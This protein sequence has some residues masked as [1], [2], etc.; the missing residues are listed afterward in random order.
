RRLDAP[1]IA[2]GALDLE[3]GTKTAVR[4]AYAGEREIPLEDRREG[5]ARHGPDDRVIQD[6]AITVPERVA[7]V[8]LEADED[9]RRVHPPPRERRLAHEVVALRPRDHEADPGL[10]G[11]LFALVLVA[12]E[13][14]AG[15]YPQRVEG[16]EPERTDSE[17]LARFEHGVPDHGAVI[18][19]TPQLIAEL[20]RVPGTRQQHR[21]P[22][23]AAQVAL[24]EPEPGQVG[25]LRTTRRWLDEPGDEV[26]APRTLNGDVVD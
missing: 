2:L 1:A 11:I 26:A 5:P 20:A 25:D 6:H 18:G 10:E 12:L 4:G 23:R 24:R 9:L 17:W 8:D 7:V 19:T 16:I 3:A 13:D 22:V 21:G 15:F 14:E